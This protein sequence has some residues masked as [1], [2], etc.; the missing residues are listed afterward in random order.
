MRILS[1][2]F[3]SIVLGGAVAVA[4]AQHR[5]P[6]TAST[7]DAAA[8]AREVLSQ[9]EALVR[10]QGFLDRLRQE[11]EAL[12]ALAP[13]PA[14]A[15]RLGTQAPM[16]D[17]WLDRFTPSPSA[18]SSDTPPLLVLVSLSMPESSLRTLARQAARIG[19]PLVLRGLVRD[20]FPATQRALARYSDIPGAAFAIDPTLFRR[21]EVSAI[22][23][24]VLPLEALQACNADTCPTPAYVRVSGEA[25]LDYVLHWIERR[26]R[27]TRARR[28]AAALSAQL[29]QRP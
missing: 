10:Q 4:L 7:E 26:A 24:Y 3:A 8:E 29:E 6:D 14:P 1:G 21:F 25:G 20:S 2:L 13:R 17:D 19:A 16:P 27:N 9:T 12:D 18:R 11:R 22:P 5:V 23:S 15:L 28:A